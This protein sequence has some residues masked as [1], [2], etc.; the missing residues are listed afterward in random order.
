VRETENAC[1][2]ARGGGKGVESKSWGGRMS[3]RAPSD[4]R[5]SEQEYGRGGREGGRERRKGGKE[6]LQHP[7]LLLL[8]LLSPAIAA[9][10]AEVDQCI[11]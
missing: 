10:H 7:S 9:A 5:A 4:E 2:E 8:R 6:N 11:Q 3:E 1:D